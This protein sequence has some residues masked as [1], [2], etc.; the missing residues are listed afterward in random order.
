MSTKYENIEE[1]DRFAL[2]GDA[3]A[4]TVVAGAQV[5][6]RLQHHA[7][8]VTGPPMLNRSNRG[9]RCWNPV[10]TYTVINRVSILRVLK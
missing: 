5:W 2:E 10:S 6:W 7:T 8:E 4:E 1:K 3:V 9:F